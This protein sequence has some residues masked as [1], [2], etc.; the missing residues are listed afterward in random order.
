[1]DFLDLSD[2][3][4]P[5]EAL[6][7]WAAERCRRPFDPAKPMFDTALV[8][9]SDGEFAWY[10]NQHHLVADGWSAL[11]IFRCTAEYYQRAAVGSLDEAAALPAFADFVAHERKVCED[12]GYAAIRSY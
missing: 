8:R 6:R 5:H 12:A 2:N 4:H 10:L 9:L 1:M 11:L 3:T 7:G